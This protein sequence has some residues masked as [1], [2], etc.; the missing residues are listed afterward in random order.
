M[1]GWTVGDVA[2]LSDVSVRTLRHYDEIGLLRP[3]RTASG[4]RRYDEDDLSRLRQILF[5]RELDFGL[6]EIAAMLADPETTTDEHLRRQHRLLRER[7]ARYGEVLAALEK[8]MEARDMGISLTP[9]EQFEIFGTDRVGGEWAAEAE[10][11]WGETQAWQQSARRSAAFTK[12]DWVQIK[13][14]AD[15]N[16]AA[17]ADLMASGVASDDPRAAAAAEAHR[18]HISRWFYDCPPEL[19]RGLAEL[20]IN[21]DRFGATYENVASGLAQYVHDAILT[22]SPA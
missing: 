17:F 5:Y 8:E 18:A 4:Y 10:Q 21:D 13:A 15:A 12:A 11:R 3:S 9:E 1:E 7:C 6:D 16:L 20:Y 2:R 19:H 14:E 22:A